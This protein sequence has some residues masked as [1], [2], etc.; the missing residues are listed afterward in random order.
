MRNYI[1]EETAKGG[2]AFFHDYGKR[3]FFSQYEQIDDQ[4]TL[5]TD[6]LTLSV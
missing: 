4:K 5:W 3:G 6:H 2:I 1:K